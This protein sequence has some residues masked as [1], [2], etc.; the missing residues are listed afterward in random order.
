[1]TNKITLSAY[2][3]INLTLAIT[4]RREDGYHTL[5]TVMQRISLADTVSVEK[6]LEGISIQCSDPKLP[7]N[8]K[9]LCWKAASAYLAQ[10]GLRRGVRIELWKAIPDGAGMGGGSA[11]AAAVLEA[12]KRLFPADV[13]LCSIAETIGAD[14][15]FCLKADTA[16]CH[17]IG[18]ELQAIPFPD[19]KRLYCVVAKSCEGVSTPRIYSLYDQMLG[20]DAPRVSRVRELTA[21]LE[22]RDLPLAFSLMQNDLELPAFRLMPEICACKAAMLEHGAQAAMMTGSGS[23]V[24]GLF[25]DRSA[26]KACEESFLQRGAFARFCTLL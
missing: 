15:P 5:E 17:G 21:A 25:S 18:T 4:G 10:A 3:K 2:A 11:D 9:N 23:A 1:M 8:E 19:K 12:M 22:K 24:F 26:A 16:F 7:C 6:T 13:D 14:V 20:Q